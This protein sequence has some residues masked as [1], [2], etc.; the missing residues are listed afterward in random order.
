MAFQSK[1]VR[2]LFLRVL[3]ITVALVVLLVS[4]V[5]VSNVQQERCVR[6]QQI[7]NAGFGSFVVC[8]SAVIIQV[9][10]T[11]VGKYSSVKANALDPVLR[12]TVRGHLHRDQAGSPLPQ[13]GQNLL[14]RHRIRRGQADRF[15]SRYHGELAQSVV[16][17]QA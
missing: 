12:Q 9:I 14:A 16:C 1:R 17:T 10:S 8:R 15:Q 7:C 5:L 11:Q 4:L 3:P 13:L 6:V 2:R